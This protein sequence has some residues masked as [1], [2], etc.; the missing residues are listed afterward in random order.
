VDVDLVADGPDR[1]EGA[2]TNVS[3]VALRDAVLCFGDQVYDQLGTLPP[4][5]AVRIDATS[6]TR[7][8]PG[9]LEER[10]QRFLN[11]QGNT[12]YLKSVGSATMDDILRVMLFRQA[13]SR[14]TMAPASPSLARLDLTGQLTLGRPMLIASIET[15]GA[16]LELEGDTGTKETVQT[17]VVRVLLPAPSR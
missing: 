10:A 13:M 16:R 3:G 12:V 15:P 11:T 5:G 4:G 6:R 9:Y 2:I 17:T 8:L 1:L 7:P 14:S